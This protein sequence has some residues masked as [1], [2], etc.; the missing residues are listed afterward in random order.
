MNMRHLCNNYSYY[1]SIN[2]LKIPIYKNCTYNYFTYCQT[3]IQALQV[4]QRLLYIQLLYDKMR[5]GGLNEPLGQ[6]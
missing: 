4:R 5:L 6:I 1:I 2:K 3:T